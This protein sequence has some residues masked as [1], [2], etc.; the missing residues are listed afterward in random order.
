MF[1][2]VKDQLN[3]F[4]HQM[5]D[6]KPNFIAGCTVL[7]SIIADKLA[8]N[9]T[10]GS[11]IDKKVSVLTT[12]Y[13]KRFGELCSSKFPFSQVTNETAKE[14]FLT[15][16]SHTHFPDDMVNILNQMLT[17]RLNQGLMLPDS[18]TWKEIEVIVTNLSAYSLNCAFENNFYACKNRDDSLAGR[19][20]IILL[21]MAFQIQTP[22][23]DLAFEEKLKFSQLEDYLNHFPDLESNITTKRYFALLLQ[24]GFL[25]QK[26]SQLICQQTFRVLQ[27]IPW[28]GWPK[29]RDHI[30]FLLRNLTLE[31]KR[32]LANVLV[33]STDPKT[34]NLGSQMVNA[35]GPD[36]TPVK[37]AEG[38]HYIQSQLLAGLPPIQC[39]HEQLF[40][41]FYYPFKKAPNQFS[42]PAACPS[43]AH[44]LNFGFRDIIVHQSQMI[45]FIKDGY[46]IRALAAYDINS[47]M[48]TWELPLDDLIPNV[49]EKPRALNNIQICPQ[50][51][52]FTT[53]E[54]NQFALIDPE[55]GKVQRFDLPP[56]ED[57]LSHLHCTPGS[58]FYH[59]SIHN[60]KRRLFGFED[61]TNINAGFV[62]DPPNGRFKR[63]GNFVGFFSEN[64]ATIIDSKG[65]AHSLPDCM[66][67]GFCNNMLYTIEISE[68]G[69]FIKKY[70]LHNPQEFVLSE[71]KGECHREGHITSIVN[72][73]QILEICDNGIC[74]CKFNGFC[75]VNFDMNTCLEKGIR[76]SS[77][78]I[79]KQNS[80]LWT[81]EADK[82]MLV[83][84]D[85][86]P[87]D[88]LIPHQIGLLE[89]ESMDILHVDAK[90]EVYFISQ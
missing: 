41:G 78:F 90:G 53:S 39:L 71:I 55:S 36:S 54:D 33:N 17:V 77:Y 19:R 49:N 61:P 81:W 22:I 25:F 31:G 56:S 6:Q 24:H 62:I 26:N 74:V 52:L 84:H 42:E 29:K 87:T 66:D 21:H 35:Y 82:K 86:H 30:I 28:E 57:Y 10:I 75:F 63:L 80:R 58:F 12:S 14:A 83:R 76:R 70:A 72:R 40:H 13:S 48:L 1:N 16:C 5:Y 67:A 59:F 44:A 2:K 8:K 89:A 73:P 34:S 79:E 38:V 45:G 60:G 7:T 50:G 46:Y 18:D 23:S 69:Y 88:G 37:R 65:N 85:Y 27:D 64:C 68:R 43:E 3:T 4:T 15:D 32:Q 11:S 47:Q 20:L 51:I 9:E